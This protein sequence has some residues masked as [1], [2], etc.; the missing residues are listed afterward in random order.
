MNYIP[1]IA[2]MLGVEI[3][4]EFHVDKGYPTL[5]DYGKYVVFTED[6]KFE[7]VGAP[8]YGSDDILIN[9]L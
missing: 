3:G 5:N 2:K 9:I 8:Y 6:E 7:V 1:E 4:E